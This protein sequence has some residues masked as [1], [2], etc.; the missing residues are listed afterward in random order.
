[1]G[2]EVRQDGGVACL[3][4][5]DI[6]CYGAFYIH[7]VM[8]HMVFTKINFDDDDRFEYY[9]DLMKR[10][11]VPSVGSQL[12]QDFRLGFIVSDRHRDVVRSLFGGRAD[13]FRSIDDACNFAISEG[14]N[15][16][17]RHDCDDWMHEG[18]TRRIKEL[19][20]ENESRGSF[21]V[22]SVLYKFVM[23]SGILYSCG[24]LSCDDGFVSPFL[25]LCQVEAKHF[26]HERNH[27][28][29]GFIGEVFCVR[30]YT[31]QVIH[32]G[33]S[34]AKVWGRSV[35]CAGSFPDPHKI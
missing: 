7:N 4:A 26:V 1:V 22:S 15:I 29:M 32:G 31:M 18:Y 23:S 33:N 20:R 6:M 8:K 10:W 28:H 13:F 3:F 14:V 5:R 11:Y 17:T 16:Q 25:S 9:L 24:S 35:P 34:L 30:G 2:L 12:D 19:Y 21:L 27:R